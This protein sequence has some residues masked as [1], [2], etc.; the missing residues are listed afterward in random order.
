MYFLPVKHNVIFVKLFF[1]LFFQTITSRFPLD[2]LFLSSIFS[3]IQKKNLHIHVKLMYVLN[4][5]PG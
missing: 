4:K 5:M 1:F 2:I 3:I